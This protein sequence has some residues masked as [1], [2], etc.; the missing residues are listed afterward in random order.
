MKGKSAFNFFNAE[1]LPWTTMAMRHSKF[2]VA[3]DVII[4]IAVVIVIFVI[5]IV[6]RLSNISVVLI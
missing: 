1:D 4:T 6:L 5:I 3:T 2:I